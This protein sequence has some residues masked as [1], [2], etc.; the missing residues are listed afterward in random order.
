LLANTAGSIYKISR[1]SDSE[2]NVGTLRFNFGR[3]RLMDSEIKV[4]QSCKN[5][6]IVEPEDFQFYERMAV[7][8]PTWCPNCRLQRR[9]LWINGK[10]LYKRQVY[11]GSQEVISM[12]SADKPF[13][14]VDDKEWWS[15]KYDLLTYGRNYDF[16]KSFFEQYK[17]L[18]EDVPLPNLQRDYAAMINSDYCNAASGL[19][20]CYLIFMADFDEDCAYGW[21]VENNKDSYDLMFTNKSEL[22]YEGIDLKDCYSCFYSKNCEDS[23]ELILCED[24]NGCNN[25]FGSI[26]LRKKSYYIF[27]RPYSKEEYFK[28]IK[29]FDLGS[30]LSLQRLKEET[31]NLFLSQPRKFIHD[32]LNKDAT[33]DYIY[34]SKNVHNVFTVEKAEDCRYSQFLRYVTTGTTHAYDYSIFGLGADLIYECA[35]CGFET[36]NLKFSFW[37]YASRNLQYCFGCHS[38]RNLFGCV[39]LRRKEYCIFNQQHTKE[40][41]EKLVSRIMQHMND[42]PYV[43]KRGRV[44]KYGEFFPTEL[45]PF[46]YNETIA[47]EYFPLEK[48]DA[49]S[50]GYQ[51]KDPE[52]KHYSITTP[53]NKLPDHIKE[54]SD[55]ILA[56][57]IGCAHEGECPHQC[58]TAFKLI[59]SELQFYR[60]MGLSLPRLCPNCRHYER[61]KQRN[62]LKLWHRKCQCAGSI[63]DNEIC[64][65][66]TMHFHASN[67]CPNEF[68]TSYTPDRP[69]IVYC[70][71]CYQAEVM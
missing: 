54:V 62:Q 10:T 12:Y 33:G 36:S 35:W 67:H 58:T 5:Q 8:P 34:Q 2:L 69:E 47:Q 40:E 68:E 22:C 41:Y 6:F 14:I 17:K 29:E 64:T 27:N 1:C 18:M 25:C 60:R 21:S 7:P 20:N 4:C 15:D 42:M 28:K 32:R 43:D 46:A 13:K 3:I 23:V 19:K 11:D 38:S 31:A 71:Q 26:N 66:T 30:F 44:Y 45:S 57:V 70:E 24:C 61:L 63:S 16:S 9:L 53:P 65:N 49:L 48:E 39:G 56:E 51:W 37:N 55:S 52:E 59:S 50:K